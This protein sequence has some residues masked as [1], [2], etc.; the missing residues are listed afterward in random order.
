MLGF[1]KTGRRDNFSLSKHFMQNKLLFNRSIFSLLLFFCFQ[2]ASYT[3]QAQSK[4]VEI[5]EMK[6]TFNQLIG[7]IKS[8]EKETTPGKKL[9]DDVR[10]RLMVLL[11]YNSNKQCGTWPSPSYKIEFIEDYWKCVFDNAPY[12]K[13]FNLN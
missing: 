4:Q 9:I 12:G 7:N 1:S 10:T 13:M 8:L 2:L 6:D 5:K 3:S 11:I